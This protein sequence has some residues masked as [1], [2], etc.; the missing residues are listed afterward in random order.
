[1][2]A[3]CDGMLD[4]KL[5]AEHLILT[6]ARIQKGIQGCFSVDN[7]APL[8]WKSHYEVRTYRNIFTP[9][10]LLNV[11]GRILDHSCV[12]DAATKLHLTP[13][14]THLWCPQRLY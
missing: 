13:V 14:A 4:Q 5:V 11:E 6:C 2:L 3:N 8:V 9:N 7:D 10:K 12:F 1:M